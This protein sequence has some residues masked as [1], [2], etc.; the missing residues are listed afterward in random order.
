[1]YRIIGADGREYGPITA[2]QLR[3]WIAEGRA[4]AL[5]RAKAEGTDYWKPLTDYAEFAP[6]L[7]RFPPSITAP[8]PISAA[9]APRT[10][11]MA[12]AAMWMGIFSVTCGLCCCYGMP[13]NLLGIIFALVALGE[14]RNEPYAQRG[15]GLAIGGL[16]LCILSFLVAAFFF[17]LGLALSTPDII[18]RLERL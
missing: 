14:I 10:N 3:G 5:T 11:S 13:F 4:N 8:G 12:L 9:P 15:R 18:R 16:V 17:V 2:E 1:M 7:T 6:L